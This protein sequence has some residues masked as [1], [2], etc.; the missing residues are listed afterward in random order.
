[1]PILMPS[2]FGDT[3]AIHP[4]TDPLFACVTFRKIVKRRRPASAHP[5]LEHQ[6]AANSERVNARAVETSDRLRWRADDR[7]AH[8]VK[9]SVQHARHAR[10]VF[11]FL[12]HLPI[13]RIRLP[14]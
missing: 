11:E 7:L 12:D 5:R 4:T 10:D 3:M 1:M 6:I 13:K 9:R 2:A 14:A 8:D